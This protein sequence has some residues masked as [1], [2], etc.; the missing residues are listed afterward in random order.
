MYGTLLHVHSIVRWFVL[1][2]LVIPL[3]RS[4]AT[5]LRPRPFSKADRISVMWGTMASHTQL[6]VGLTLYM[7][8]PFVKFF[9][10]QPAQG[11]ANGQFT[12]TAIMG[13]RSRKP[14]QS[15]HRGVCSDCAEHVVADND[16]TATTPGEARRC[17]LA[18]VVPLPVVGASRRWSTRPTPGSVF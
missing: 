8:S 12:T 5:L 11:F 2:G 17:A 14:H 15:W 3:A 9:W 4:Y 6:L 16:A 18:V 10:S 7:S 1:I 13:E